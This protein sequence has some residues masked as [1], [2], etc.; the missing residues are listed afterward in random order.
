MSALE[1]PEHAAHLK[2][3]IEDIRKEFSS[4]KVTSVTPAAPTCLPRIKSCNKCG[5]TFVKN[6]ELEN[7]MV[8]FQG[9]EKTRGCE[10]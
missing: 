4:L 7:H 6:F 10:I 1:G 9:L 2:E 3:K 8:H 5:E